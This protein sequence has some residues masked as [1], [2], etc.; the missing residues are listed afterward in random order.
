MK[1][2]IG[3]YMHLLSNAKL[4]EDLELSDINDLINEV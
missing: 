1:L 2:K 3:I 4:G